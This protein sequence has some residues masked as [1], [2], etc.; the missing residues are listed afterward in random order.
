MRIEYKR[1]WGCSCIPFFV[2]ASC[3]DHLRKVLV[4][5][6]ELVTWQLKKWQRNGEFFP[7]LENRDFLMQKQKN[8]GYFS[9][10]GR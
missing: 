1:G 5:G 8:W 4:A 2:G 7:M 6:N 10:E 3:R 9:G